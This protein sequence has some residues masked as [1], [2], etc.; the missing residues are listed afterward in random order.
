MLVN[1]Q[2]APSSHEL[3]RLR[4]VFNVSWNLHSASR[5]VVFIILICSRAYLKP[6]YMLELGLTDPCLAHL[7]PKENNL[8][9]HSHNPVSTDVIQNVLRPFWFDDGQ[10]IIISADNVE[11]K[12]HAGLLTY[13]SGVLRKMI[14]S[15]QEHA[16]QPPCAALRLPE[17]GNELSALFCILY[18]G[19]KRCVNCHIFLRYS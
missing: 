8:I 5:T 6:G 3:S 4:R 10:L 19:G 11:F 16:G 12:I 18:D 7:A 2:R 14:A 9:E 17:S 1:A 15:S 13:H